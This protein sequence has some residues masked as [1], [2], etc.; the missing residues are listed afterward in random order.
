ML[1]QCCCNVAAILLEFQ[2]Q[3][4]LIAVQ[5]Q[6]GTD[7]HNAGHLGSIAGKIEANEGRG[8]G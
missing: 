4:I 6:Q 8:K 2:L 5:G 3:R 7:R 1:L